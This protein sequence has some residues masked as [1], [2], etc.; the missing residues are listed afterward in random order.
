MN[1][2]FLKNKLA[3]GGILPEGYLRFSPKATSQI[4]SDN[5]AL[6]FSSMF[7]SPC[8]SVMSKSAPKS[9]C[10]CEKAHFTRESFSMEA[11]DETRYDDW[12]D[13]FHSKVGMT[14][15]KMRK[16]PNSLVQIL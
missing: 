15:E 5:E 7:N 3:K 2:R 8:S 11:N 16:K 12:Q 13:Y 9:G 14:S 1:T 4:E 6:P 10:S